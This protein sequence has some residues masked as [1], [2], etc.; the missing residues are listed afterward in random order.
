MNQFI[1]PK[2]ILFSLPTLCESAPAVEPL[3]RPALCRSL[4]EDDW[5]QIEFVPLTNR[6]H[7]DKELNALASFKQQHRSGPGWTNVYVRREHPTPLAAVG[8]R[9][10]NM[11]RL[12]VS[13]VWL[14]PAPPSGGLV[15]GGFALSDSTNWSLYGQRSPDGRVLQLSLLHSASAMSAAMAEILSRLSLDLRL[16]VVDWFATAVVDTSSPES[17]LAWAMRYQKL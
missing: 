16:I 6:A 15:K 3:P 14:G 13:A 2:N 10:A 12:P 11:P 5:R 17:V 1:D 7:I 4:H 8:L 9:F